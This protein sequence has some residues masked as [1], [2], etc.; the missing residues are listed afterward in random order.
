MY[1]Y[2][3]SKE[4]NSRFVPLMESL[5]SFKILMSSGAPE[6][7][8]QLGVRLWSGHDLMGS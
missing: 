1:I 6:W 5:S 4:K 2:I 3:F 7:L 8:S